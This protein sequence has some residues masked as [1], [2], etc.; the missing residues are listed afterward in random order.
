MEREGGGG[1]CRLRA[2][3]DDQLWYLIAFN[4]SVEG[5][6]SLLILFVP[7]KRGFPGSAPTG[8]VQR[9]TGLWRRHADPFHSNYHSLPFF[10][11]FSPPFFYRFPSFLLFFFFKGEFVFSTV[12]PIVNEISCR[13]EGN[14]DTQMAVRYST[15]F[16]FSKRS[17]SSSWISLSIKLCRVIN[18]TM[19]LFQKKKTKEF[20][21]SEFK[22]LQVI[23]EFVE[24]LRTNAKDNST[25]WQTTKVG[26]F[27]ITSTNRFLLFW[28][29]FFT[30]I[31]HLQ[32]S[33]V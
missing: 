28:G 24:K 11:F 3:R 13:S 33:K 7:Q 18:F 16:A 2:A 20:R 10:S 29:L 14:Y 23:F 8:I 15:N 4:A 25:V 21:Q 31:S 12:V 19:R 5:A 30:T 32:R 27:A 9:I 17:C 22:Q 1:A 6:R 26:I